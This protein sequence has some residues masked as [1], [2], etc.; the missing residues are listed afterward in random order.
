MSQ[1]AS[2]RVLTVPNLISFTRLLLVP[3]FLWVLLA[4]AEAIAFVLLA[5]I[6]GSDW[7]DGFVARRT[8]QISRLGKLLDPVADR[9]AIASLVVGLGLRGVIPWPAAAAIIGRDVLVAVAFAILERRRGPRLPVN[10]AGK[11]ATSLIYAGCGLAGARL[12]IESRGDTLPALG[13]AL[14]V[15]LYAGAVLYWV[16]GILYAMAL[17]RVTPGAGAA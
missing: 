14:W 16:A 11:V 1:E 8:G 5:L 3:I 15:L 17:R 12:L 13:P 2:S 9:I 10:L 7:V 4:G 6:G